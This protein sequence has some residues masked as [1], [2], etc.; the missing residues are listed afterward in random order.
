VAKMKKT[1]EII[2]KGHTLG[3]NTTGVTALLQDLKNPKT[4]KQKRR[5]EAMSKHI[6]KRKKTM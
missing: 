5:N 4:L 6:T 3:R 2:E 1:K